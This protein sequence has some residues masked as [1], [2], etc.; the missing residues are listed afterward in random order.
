[1]AILIQSDPQ[2]H[3]YVEALAALPSARLLALLQEVFRQRDYKVTHTDW[4][5]RR[6]FVVEQSGILDPSTGYLQP[7]SR[8]DPEYL[9]LSLAVSTDETEFLQNGICDSCGL[10]VTCTE[11]LAVCPF[12]GATVECT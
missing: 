7:D 11:K 8:L 5:V 9:A 10:E 4:E 12:C 2:D 3:D 1:M 6:W